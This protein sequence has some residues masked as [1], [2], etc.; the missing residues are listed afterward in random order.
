MQ[1]RKGQ[2]TALTSQHFAM[3]GQRRG[4]TSRR[5]AVTGARSASSDLRSARTADAFH[6]ARVFARG[7]R[8]EG[9]RERS[10]MIRC[11]TLGTR[12]RGPSARVSSRSPSNE[13][14]PVHRQRRAHRSPSR[15]P[16]CSRNPRRN[17]RRS[18]GARPPIIRGANRCCAHTN[19]S[20]S[21]R[22]GHIRL[23]RRPCDDERSRPQH[24][25][26]RGQFYWC[27]SGD[28]SNGV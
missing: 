16:L 1:R 4:Q 17:N 3:N 25:N 8:S 2:R 19:G 5:T 15:S 11:A 6:T 26:N 13:C 14:S 12:G 7:Q 20:G 22:L 18:P 23:R 10:D 27:N 28:I 24:A 21:T 9:V